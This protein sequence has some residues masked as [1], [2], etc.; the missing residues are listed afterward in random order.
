MAVRDLAYKTVNASYYRGELP[1]SLPCPICFNPTKACAEQD[2]KK[3]GL[4][5]YC[6]VCEQGR[7][8]IET[9]ASLL[10]V[11]VD[12]AIVLMINRGLIVGACDAQIEK[13][14]KTYAA[15]YQARLLWAAAKKEFVA[16][17]RELWWPYGGMWAYQPPSFISQRAAVIRRSTLLAAYPQVKPGDDWFSAVLIVPGYSRPGQISGFRVYGNVE[18]T[19]QKSGTSIPVG[20]PRAR[21]TIGD[22]WKVR[23]GNKILWSANTSEALQLYLFSGDQDTTKVCGPLFES[24]T[25]AEVRKMTAYAP[26]ALWDGEPSTRLDQVAK[27]LNLPAYYGRPRS[28][29][30]RVATW[31]ASV[32]RQA[33]S[34]HKK[35]NRDQLLAGTVVIKNVPVTF[36]RNKVISGNTEIVNGRM[37]VTTRFKF[38]SRRWYAGYFEREKEIQKFCA[39]AGVLRTKQNYLSD[40]YVE[41]AKASPTL[42]FR[43]SARGILL[44]AAIMFQPPKDEDELYGTGWVKDRRSYSFRGFELRPSGLIVPR[45]VVLRQK[46]DLPPGK[47]LRSRITDYL[48][49]LRSEARQY[50]SATVILSAAGMLRHMYGLK[51]VMWF[52]KNNCTRHSWHKLG[53]RVEIIRSMEVATVAP[54]VDSNFCPAPRWT[55]L[56]G[57][58]RKAYTL[59]QAFELQ[60]APYTRFVDVVDLKSQAYGVF[61]LPGARIDSGK[62]PVNVLPDYLW[63]VMVEAKSILPDGDSFESRVAKSIQ[64]W[65]DACIRVTDFGEVGMSRLT[66]T[67]R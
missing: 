22:W 15:A 62:P 36:C 49:S 21:G 52:S 2:V 61:D 14:K 16:M 23:P 51:P 47:Q 29:A 34:R 30:T 60:P 50:V 5:F 4:W 12:A 35:A 48:S 19:Q 10:Q 17:D 9:V 38:N 37:V 24:W 32:V 33:E 39:P 65:V 40:R 58:A 11:S 1:S 56:L 59:Y 46:A 42:R 28:K 64:A 31:A 63:W 3:A 55:Y 54:K 20:E 13:Y 43:Q 44:K 67:P 66:I 53:G 27:T 18:E 7:D 25:L 8:E 6:Q 45:P 57:E 41:P 26:V